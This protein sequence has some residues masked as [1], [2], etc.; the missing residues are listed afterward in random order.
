MPISTVRAI[1]EKFK[2]TRAVVNL[3]GRG[4]KCILPLCTVKRIA[5]QKDH[6]WRFT[7]SDN[8]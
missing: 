7:D 6:S 2:T 1:I 5:R 3:L 4:R 8:I